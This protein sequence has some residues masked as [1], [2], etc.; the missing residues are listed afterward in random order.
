MA[1]RLNSCAT[2]KCIHGRAVQV[3]H[4]SPICNAPR[5]YKLPAAHYIPG[6]N[7]QFFWLT[8][9]KK[10][11]FFSFWPPSFFNF[12]TYPWLIGAPRVNMGVKIFNIFVLPG[13]KTFNFSDLPVVHYY[14]VPTGN[15]TFFHTHLWVCLFI[16]LNNKK[17]IYFLKKLYVIIL[18]DLVVTK[19]NKLEFEHIL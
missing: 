12:L 19:Q 9:R 13:M 15:S 14:W 18:R 5:V 11:Q 6:G 4:G 2:G 17:L 1:H 16:I 7:F 3:T 10:L 8:R